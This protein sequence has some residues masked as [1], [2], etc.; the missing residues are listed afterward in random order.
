MDETRTTELNK[1]LEGTWDSLTDEQKVK[2]KACGSM[3]EL[4][5]LAGEA[6]VEL[7]DEMLDVVAGGASGQTGKLYCPY[8][9]QKEKADRFADC[10]IHPEGDVMHL[11]IVEHYRCRTKGKDFYICMQKKKY[12]DN[13]EKCIGNYVETSG[14]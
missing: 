1:A 2:A 3:D 11:I 14:C 12:Y 6:G 13:Q 4:A 9:K 5:M 10:S 8:C 7:P